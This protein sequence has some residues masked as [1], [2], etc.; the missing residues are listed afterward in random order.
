MVSKTTENTIHFP[1]VTGKLYRTF[2]HQRIV[3]RKDII[4][5]Y[6]GDVKKSDLNIHRLLKSGRAIRIKANVYYFKTPQEFY[7]GN[8]LV[9]PLLV[10]GRVHPEGAIVNHAAL[11]VTGN[12]YSV[13]THYQ[14]GIPKKEKTPRPFEFQNASYRYYRTD[15]SF[16]LEEAIIQDVTVRYFSPERI[17]LEGLMHQDRFFG[18]AELLQ[19]VE[20]FSYA[21]SDDL[22]SMLPNYPV[23]TAA[24]RLGWL[25][26]RFQKRWYI[27][28]DMLNKL[29]Q[30]RTVNRLFLVPNKRK[31][32]K[33]VRR[34]NLM[35]PKTLDY[36]DEG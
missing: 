31:Y 32:N 35:V 3:H 17:L 29:E 6:N 5:F 8:V 11:R 4:N 18:I 24:M 36:L 25:L 16:G 10:T 28:E 22:L 33:L 20:G 12:A 34:W 14:V 21:N 2:Q 7:D 1:T 15:L 30:Y 13:S 9:E 27:P 26:E 19:S 23:K